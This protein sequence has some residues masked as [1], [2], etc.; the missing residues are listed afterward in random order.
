MCLCSQKDMTRF[1]SSSPLSLC[2]SSSPAPISPPHLTHSIP[3]RFADSAHFPACPRRNWY[4]PT[5]RIL[6]Q[7][8][9]LT[10]IPDLRI[11]TGNY[12]FTP[13]LFL[14]LCSGTLGSDWA[15]SRRAEMLITSRW[16][17]NK[18]KEKLSDPVH[19]YSKHNFLSGG[20][21]NKAQY[22]VFFSSAAVMWLLNLNLLVLHC[23]ISLVPCI[24]SISGGLVKHQTHTHI[25]ICVHC[26]SELVPLCGDD[27]L[28][29]LIWLPKLFLYQLPKNISRT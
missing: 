6:M 28:S 14:Q 25:Y 24:I 12:R 1:S 15:P 8:I 5:T 19:L 17:N 27:K 13:S 10:N 29:P 23:F 26:C 16:D 3:A 7:S 4:P 20:V 18:V 21:S 11:S 9:L 2:F 22:F